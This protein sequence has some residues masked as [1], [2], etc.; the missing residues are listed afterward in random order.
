MSKNVLHIIRKSSQLRSTFIKNQITVHIRYRPYIVFKEKS[1][2]PYDGGYA[3]FDSEKFEILDLSGMKSEGKKINKYL[4]RI[5]TSDI[6]AIEKFIKE[7]SI[8][9]LHFHYGTDAGLYN[10][11]IEKSNLPSLIS[12]YGY[13]ASSFPKMFYGLGK[14]F[15]KRRVFNTG[16][17]MTAMTEDMKKDLVQLGCDEKKIIVHYHGVGGSVYYYP[18]RKYANRDKII[19]LIVSYLAP[20]KGHLFLFRGIR[21]LLNRG[22]RNFELRVIGTGELENEL[23]EFVSANN[24]CDYIKFLGAM[25]AHSPEILSEYRNADIFTHPSV[26]PENGDKEGIPGTVVEAMFC[27]LPVVSTYH[28]GI[29]YIIENG[30]TGLL[31]KEWDVN[32]IAD[33]ISLLMSDSELRKKIGTNAMNYAMENLILSKKEAMLE[34]IYDNLISTYK[35]KN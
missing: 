29:P 13:D 23:K 1:D 6:N 35:S 10:K 33:S 27:G 5:S 2:K 24:L 17:M 34:E 30:K 32:K 4:K 12:F 15:L 9:I 8:D 14:Q 26:I 18:E 7:K 20:Q 25:K 21:E 22:I 31:V 28:A 11:L 3:D 16:A 19:L